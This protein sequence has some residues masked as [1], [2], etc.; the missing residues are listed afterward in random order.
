MKRLILAIWFACIATASSAATVT[1]LN[2]S[3]YVEMISK[4]FSHA[5]VFENGDFRGF[6]ESAYMTWDELGIPGWGGPDIG[7]RFLVN[8]LIQADESLALNSFV[9]TCT[10]AGA[11]F[12]GSYSFI[13]GQFD[14]TTVSL[15]GGGGSSNFF[16]WISRLGG[17]SF[18]ENDAWG[19]GYL[20]DGRTWLFED[21][22]SR[23]A[24]F[25]PVPLPSAGWLLLA[26]LGLLAH[27]RRPKPT[28]H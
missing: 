3:F 22:Y 10:G 15:L 11:T 2:Q 7:D 4:S 28:P 20:A 23:T 26:A 9:L 27:R 14:G 12:C 17:S 19:Q 13:E 5:Q 24:Q 1:L 25:T 18:Y 21:G 16:L 8:V 6:G